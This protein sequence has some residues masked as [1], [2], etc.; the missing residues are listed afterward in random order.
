MV[1]SAISKEMALRHAGFGGVGTKIEHALARSRTQ[2]NGH[3]QSAAKRV[4]HESTMDL[5][6]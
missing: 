2:I 1:E 6:S 5:T 3:H 4:V